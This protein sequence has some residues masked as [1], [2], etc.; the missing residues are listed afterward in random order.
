MNNRI[1]M[2]SILLMGVL[3]FSTISYGQNL[4]GLGLFKLGSFNLRQLDMVAQANGERITFESDSIKLLNK[5]L[6][7]RPKFYQLAWNLRNTDFNC[8][9]LRQYGISNFE[10]D[11]LKLSNIRLT[12]V[13][14]VLYEIKCNANASLINTLTAKYK[15]FKVSTYKKTITCANDYYVKSTTLK[16]NVVYYQWT[17]KDAFMAVKLEKAYTGDCRLVTS[18]VLSVHSLKMAELVGQKSAY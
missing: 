6:S 18:Q 4:E 11:G 3:L 2:K 9:G 5:S 13:D 8:K 14:S 10:V 1:E 17:F 16:D 15:N 12:F 7:A